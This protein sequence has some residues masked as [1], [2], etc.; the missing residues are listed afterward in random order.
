[1]N[2]QYSIK[3]Y[4]YQSLVALLDSFKSDWESICVEPND[5][6]EKVDIRWNYP[7]GRI[8]VVQVKSSKNLFHLSAIKKWGEELESA[9]PNAHEYKLVLIGNVAESVSSKIGNVIIESKN[10]SIEDFQSII[11]QKINSFYEDNGKTSISS[12]LCKLFAQALNHVILVNSVTGKVVSRDEFKKYLL[13]SFGAIEEQLKRSPFSLILPDTPSPNEDI[14]STIMNNILRLFGW[15]YMTKGENQSM[16]NEKLGKDILY[17]LD[18]WADYESP[19]KDNSRDILYIN[20]NHDIDYSQ[21][22]QTEV[23]EGLYSFDIIRDKLVNQNKVK[24]NGSYEYYINFVLSLGDHDQGQVI[25]NGSSMFKENL[26]NKNVIYYLIDNAKLNF[27]VSSIVTA[28]NYRSSLPVKFLYPITEDNSDTQKIG[29]RGTYMPPQFLN[30]SIIPI[31]KE[32]QNK[33]S[34]LL[35][36]SDRFDKDNLKKIIWLS[37]RL[38]S[39][40]AN[41]YILYFPDYDSDKQGIVTEVVRS[42]NNN[43]LNIKVEKIS[44][45]NVDSL[46]LIPT[47]YAETLIDESYNENRNKCLRIKPHLIEYLPYGDSMKPFL[48][49][50]AVKSID[51][52]A[53]L[54]NKGIFLKSADKTRIIQLMTSMLFSSVDINSLIAFVNINE[55]PL[56]TTSKQYKLFDDINSKNVI[57]QAINNIYPENYQSKLKAK[58]VSSET[59][60][61]SDGSITIKTYIEETNPNKQALVNVTSSISQVTISVDLC[62]K[63]LDF[64]KEYNSKPAKALSDRLVDVITEQL[65][66]NN[67]IEDKADEVLFSSF[68]NLERANYLL[69]FTNI[70]SSNIFTDFNA[71]SIKYMFDESATLPQEYEDKKGKECITQLTGKNLDSIRELQD[72]A[73]KSI[74]LCEEISINYRFKIRDITGRYLVRIS[75]SDAL[76]NMPNPD[77]IFTY[78]PKCFINSY[79]KEKVNSI[80]SL[81]KELKIE[82]IR[83][84][85]EKLKTF[86]KI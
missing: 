8:S 69:S 52:K 37:L 65:M 76:K 35:F 43:D 14:K 36:C 71:Q 47:D 40:L 30:S 85:K 13:D 56:S 64:T 63:K 48:A 49:S 28:K 22:I 4:I 73:L 78:T 33:I 60:Q 70:D 38:T 67:V 75:F 6:S 61:N 12:K 19:L 25:P 26:L 53:F 20:S 17:S 59:T 5:E 41:E 86:N 34:V 55:K 15:G 3:G 51:L 83:L 21:N 31:I 62:T 57:N 80:Q 77:G 27:L 9:T 79:C 24:A 66:H 7:D 11:M 2:G 82:F 50:D 84:V 18:Y 16:Y 46:K 68:S 58:V 23:K 54:S 39:G 81:E 42:Y 10:M 1:M 32:D 74:I 29:K 72:Q 45:I 44:N